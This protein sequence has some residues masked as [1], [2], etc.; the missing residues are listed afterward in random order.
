MNCRIVVYPKSEASMTTNMEVDI[1]KEQN[2]QSSA[3]TDP[4]RLLN[5]TIFN[6]TQEV[7]M[8]F[9]GEA[10][11]GFDNSI[12][13]LQPGQH[14]VDGFD[15][16]GFYLPSDRTVGQI[17]DTAK[18]GPAAVKIKDYQTMKVTQ[19]GNFYVLDTHNWGVYRQG[20]L[21]WD[22]RDYTYQQVKEW[23]E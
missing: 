14:T 20:E 10:Q 11:G 6:E 17:V 22:I 3:V 16:D 21:N 23:S 13:S 7:L 4:R 2:G 8:V 12:V 5:G 19:D 9:G 15:C 1:M 18:Q